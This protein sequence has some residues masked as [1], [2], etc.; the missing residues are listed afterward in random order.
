MAKYLKKDV[1]GI[2]ELK[3]TF[4]G[5]VV[6]FSTTNGKVGL[7]KT[8]LLKHITSLDGKITHDDLCCNL[9]KSLERLD[10]HE[11]DV[12]RF[13]ATATVYSK[14]CKY[15]WEELDYKFNKLAKIRKSK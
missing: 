5:I 15:E 3:G 11:G 1:N 2:G 8:V 7:Q 14:R 4:K 12:V 10:L 6:G 9:T 13:D